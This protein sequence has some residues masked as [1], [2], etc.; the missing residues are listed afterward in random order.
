MP[1]IILGSLS[2]KII[3]IMLWINSELLT[4]ESNHQVK[5]YILKFSNSTLSKLIPEEKYMTL[6]R[7]SLMSVV[8]LGF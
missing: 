8:F 1:L 6:Y 5:V 2:I 4:K 3:G 7:F